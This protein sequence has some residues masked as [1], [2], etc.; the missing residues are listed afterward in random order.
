MSC[1]ILLIRQEV[2]DKAVLE[3]QRADFIETS[4]SPLA[5]QVVM[6]PK[7]GDK[8]TFCAD[9]RHLRWTW[10]GGPPGSLCWT[11]W[12]VPGVPLHRYQSQN[13]FL[14]QFKVL[15]FSL[16]NTQVTFER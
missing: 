10:F 13:Y 15:R 9:Y 6:V 4:D 8:L 2:A 11:S 7:K 5:A 3:K 1:Y 14:Q 16:C 12:L